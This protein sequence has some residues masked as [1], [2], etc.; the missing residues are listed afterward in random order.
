[1]YYMIVISVS[2]LEVDQVIVYSYLF[3]SLSV[4]YP[5]VWA[6]L[7][8]DVKSRVGEKMGVWKWG[9]L[10]VVDG[11]L[12]YGL[13]GL[14]GLAQISLASSLHRRRHLHTANPYV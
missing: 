5:P 14:K 6:G 4:I 9:C 8:A 12:S 3:L 7:A 1:M 11:V 10:F 13:V 2:K